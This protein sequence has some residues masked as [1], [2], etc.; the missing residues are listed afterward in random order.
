MFLAWASGES[1]QLFIMFYV[2]TFYNQLC[3]FQMTRESLALDKKLQSYRKYNLDT[4][5]S[6][7]FIK[8]FYSSPNKGDLKCHF[9]HLLNL[10]M[11]MAAYWGF[12]TV[13]LKK[14]AAKSEFTWVSGDLFPPINSS[15]L[16]RYWF[17]K[18][19]GRKRPWRSYSQVITQA[20][21][22]GNVIW[23]YVFCFSPVCKQTL[24]WSSCIS[25]Y[26]PNFW[27]LLFGRSLW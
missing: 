5:L 23:V 25:S 1:T 26:I 2:Q 13:W 18:Q 6:H 3:F 19:F 24:N 16:N 14:K 27:V 9:G 22:A 7:F 8:P 12:L 4:N 11:L 15:E 21:G 17:S 10:Y 20:A